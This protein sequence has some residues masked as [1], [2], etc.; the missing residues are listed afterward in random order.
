MHHPIIH[1]LAR[2]RIPSPR[3]FCMTNPILYSFTRY[4]LQPR[5]GK[6][7]MRQ[8]YISPMHYI[9]PSPERKCE[10]L[11]AKNRPWYGATTVARFEPR[12]SSRWNYDIPFLFGQRTEKE[13]EAQVAT[14]RSESPLFP[15]VSSISG[16]IDVGEAGLA[17]SRL[18]FDDEEQPCPKRQRYAKIRDPCLLA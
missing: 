9:V 11:K 18:D 7:S 8:V 17:T 2:K 6:G 12:A 10:Y 4:Q 16:T 15:S 13:H 14:F 5:S 3:P 1:K